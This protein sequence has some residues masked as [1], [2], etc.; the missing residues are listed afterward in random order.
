MPDSQ[1]SA[2]PGTRFLKVK[3]EATERKNGRSSSV[4][5]P[6]TSCGHSNLCDQRLESFGYGI[7]VGKFPGWYYFVTIRVKNPKP[8]CNVLRYMF[9]KHP[10]SFRL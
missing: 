7:R 1:T 6:V 9:H 4:V 2:S 3:R 5:F 8:E 10:T